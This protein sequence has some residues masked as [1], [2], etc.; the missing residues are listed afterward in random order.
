M[1]S[2][3]TLGYHVRTAKPGTVGAGI[4]WEVDESV[5]KW[6]GI[7][8]RNSALAAAIGMRRMTKPSLAQGGPPVWSASFTA[9]AAERQ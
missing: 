3:Q 7:G 5:K 9:L 8:V 4:E 6:S 2:R 1:V